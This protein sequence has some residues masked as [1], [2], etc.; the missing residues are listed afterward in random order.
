METRWFDREFDFGF[1]M[2]RYTEL[3]E[4]IQNAP[5]VFQR[6]VS[7][8]SG[9]ILNYKPANKWSV[10]EHIGHLTLLEPLWR[11]RS[12]EIKAG[13]PELSPAD[14]S[15]RATDEASFNRIPLLDLQQRFAEERN[16]TLRLLDSLQPDDFMNASL[17]P[18]L[19]RPMR[20]VDL[21]YFVAEHDDHH[22]AAIRHII[23]GNSNR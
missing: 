6:T 14:L 18:R 9:N 8:D 1:G 2:E 16:L 17:H 21:L 7:P 5:V 23:N 11:M 22:L 4:R 12:G 15:N 20:I 10:K 3:Y 13:R 19:Q